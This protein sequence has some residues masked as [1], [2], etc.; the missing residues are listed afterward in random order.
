[1]HYKGS[2]FSFF[3]VIGHISNRVVSTP[4]EQ[5]VMCE[6]A[7]KFIKLERSAPDLVFA[8]LPVISDITTL[9]NLGK[10]AF[11]VVNLGQKSDGEKIA[12][13]ELAMPAETTDEIILEKFHEF[14]HEVF[15]M[16]CAP[17]SS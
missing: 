17:S 4:G 14:H 11:G 3:D 8:Q 10:G 16:R 7:G 5:G 12:I 2:R 1:M 6:A 13:K 9:S 15:I